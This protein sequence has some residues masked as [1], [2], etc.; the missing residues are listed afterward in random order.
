MGKSGRN[1][2]VES[3]LEN[4]SVVVE[5]VCHRCAVD[6]HAGRE[7]YE[8]VPLTDHLEEEVDVRTFVDEESN[9]MSIN[10][11]LNS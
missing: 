6:L 7:N 2:S 9:R 1:L 3:A 8:V 4:L 5:F 10:N 11:N